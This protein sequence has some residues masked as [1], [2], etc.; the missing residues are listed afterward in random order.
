MINKER[1]VISRIN[2]WDIFHVKIFSC[3]SQGLLFLFL[4]SFPLS[5]QWESFE[6]YVVWGKSSKVSWISSLKNKI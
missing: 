4:L 5:L 2:Y 1:I 3:S 6:D